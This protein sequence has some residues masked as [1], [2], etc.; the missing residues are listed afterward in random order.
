MRLYIGGTEV[1]LAPDALPEFSYSLVEIIDPSKTRGSTSTT[2]DIP[3]T[4]AT[5]VA[6]GGPAMN[7]TVETEQSIRIGDSGQVLFEGV[8]TPVEWTEDKVSIAAFG[9]N[10]DW[11][12]KAKN[13]KCADV[14]LG[15]SGPV[16]NSMQEASWT[17][18]DRADVYPL[19]DYGAL[20]NH[21]ASTNVI[22]DQLYP[23]VRVHRILG[24]FFQT[25]GFTVVPDGGFS[26]IWKKLIIPYNG[27]PVL[28]DGDFNP[29][30][31][32]RL[33]VTTAA[34]NISTVGMKFDTEDNDPANQITAS[35]GYYTQ[36]DPLVDSR[37][38]FAFDGTISL[39]RP[40]P[41]TSPMRL[42]FELWDVTGTDVLVTARRFDI[43]MNGYTALVTL[44]EILFEV[45]MDK[46]RTYE[47]RLRTF[48]P[49]GTTTIVQA[50]S[51]LS[52]QLT[53][54]DGYQSNIDFDISKTIDSKMTIADLISAL[55][56]IYRLAIR[57]DQLSN[58]VTVG[59]LDDYLG[60]IGNGI[61]WQDRVDHSEL[62]RKVLPEI[63]VRYRF[64]YDEDSDD[65]YLLEYKR[66]NGLGIGDGTFEVGGRDEEVYVKLKFA[67]TA[68]G[69]RFGG[70]T[71]PIISEE[72]ESA[73]QDFL[74]IKPRI[75]VFD[76]LADGEWTF[77][78]TPLERYPRAYFIGEGNTDMGLGFATVG[79]IHGTIDRHWRN[80]LVRATRPYFKGMVKLYDDEF[81]N[82]K[83]GR[84][85]LVR[86]AYGPFWAYVQKISGKK[87]GDGSPVECELIPV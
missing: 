79:G 49:L 63:P 71:V 35:G 15:N 78:G 85:R 6:L 33:S 57:T 55:S 13:T 20:V 21:T 67:G 61:D 56:N 36:I 51:T 47:V 75:L 80:F 69:T 50:G 2:F 37:M 53:G 86:D 38:R 30:Y 45:L 74:D 84:P 48:P 12:G 68:E 72:D 18:E 64:E 16:E 19:I 17:D 3:N 42:F 26:R 82:F 65:Q 43:P 87:F 22:E 29:A 9:D 10:A 24:V 31:S 54:Y 34:D 1:Q 77:D 8:C 7:E 62:P 14:K 41:G 73:V 23:A 28:F 60:G 25:L 70:L 83:F 46:T 59:F 27:G 58:T 52:M 81:M 40:T 76:G 4:N 66:A 32:A 44:N 5:R 39:E 11:I